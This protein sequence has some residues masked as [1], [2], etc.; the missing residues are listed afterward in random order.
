MPK[1]ADDMSEPKRRPLPHD[2]H[3]TDWAAFLN[4]WLADVG[5]R[6]NWL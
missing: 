4:Q 2:F 5:G 3:S 6:R 1:E